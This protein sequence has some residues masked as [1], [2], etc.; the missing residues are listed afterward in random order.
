MFKFRSLL[1]DKRKEMFVSIQSMADYE[2]C[3]LSAHTK[4]IKVLEI[5]CNDL[6]FIKYLI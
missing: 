2:L 5:S 6:D 4:T 1:Y 3:L